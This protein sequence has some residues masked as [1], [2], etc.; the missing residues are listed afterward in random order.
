VI[1][2]DTTPLVALCDGRDAH[3]TLAMRQL[4][5]LG[6]AREAFATCE[7][8]LT[9]TCFHL[10]HRAQRLRLRALVDALDVQRLPATPD[11]QLWDDVLQWLV[12]Y[13]DH[14]P[15]WADACLAVLAGRDAS[16]KVWTYD[17]EF[18]TTWRRPDGTRIPVL[19]N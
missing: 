7:S 12:K 10:P 19:A 15:D 11:V 17:A 3:H 13:A 18:R 6:R 9:E 5:T 4:D 8:V 14:E 16:L 2:I 1:L